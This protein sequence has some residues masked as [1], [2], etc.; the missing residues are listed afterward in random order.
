MSKELFNGIG[1]V[2]DDEI[3]ST[4]ANINRIIKHFEEKN[5]P[6]VKYTS[7][8]NIKIIDNL[9]AISFLVFDWNLV[10]FIPGIRSPEE[11]INE[12]NESNISFL[13]AL[14]EKCFCPIFI[15]TN[16]NIDDIKRI[17]VGSNLYQKK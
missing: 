5:I 11:I 7:L 16:E 10:N 14:I 9:Q 3:D 17:L 15:F 13:R 2:I 1:I 12:N 6:L 8:P 4:G